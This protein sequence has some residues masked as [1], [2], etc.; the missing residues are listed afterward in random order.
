MIDAERLAV[1]EEGDALGRGRGVDLGP[2]GLLGP[3]RRRQDQ[4]HVGGGR[5][6]DRGASQRQRQQRGR[7]QAHPAVGDLASLAEHE[8]EV[9][10]PRSLLRSPTRTWTHGE[11]AAER[12]FEPPPTKLGMGG[13]PYNR[14]V[15]AMALLALLITAVIVAFAGS[16]GQG[17]APARPIFHA[18]FERGFEGFNFAGVG[19]VDPTIVETPGGSGDHAAKF[20]LEGSQGRS[21]LIVG[22]SGDNST[23]GTIEFG[24]G[25][26]RWLGF[27]FKILRM[28][29]ASPRYW[30]LIMQLKGE[31]EGSPN[32]ALQVSGEGDERGIWTSGAAMGH[33]R[34]LA[35]LGL[36][37][38]HR[39]ELHFRASNN[40]V[41]FYQLY[42]DGRLIDQ[43]RNVDTIPWYRDRAYLKLGIYR[44][45]DHLDTSSTTLVDDVRLGR[46]RA[47][48][49]A[50]RR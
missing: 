6:G 36:R 2:Q 45:G 15:R 1:D 26:E 25:D 7:R 27:S 17:A 39:I 42:L 49:A 37:Q 24:E 33:S 38:W 44:D 21:E 5:V 46:T 48:V 9:G 8:T 11:R 50:S 29:F 31:G 47:A 13:D 18:G 10:M 3:Q 16:G 32:F 4:P 41:G 30:N 35:P 28:N 23:D 40:G 43:R 14:P 34:F 22:G 19:D 20:T 12:M